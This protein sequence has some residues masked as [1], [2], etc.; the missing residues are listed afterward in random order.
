M[1]TLELWESLS[2]REE[3]EVEA[4]HLPRDERARLAQALISS[5]DE[6]SEVEQ[7]WNAE[8]RRRVA[9]LDAGTV[10]TIPAEQV[11]AELNALL[12]K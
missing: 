3:L 5:L 11:F 12:E 7:A 2:T 1:R 10:K 6:E 4:L 8:I 9:E